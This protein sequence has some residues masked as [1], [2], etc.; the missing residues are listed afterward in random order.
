[1]E[2]VR[3]EGQ[4]GEEDDKEWKVNVGKMEERF[5]NVERQMRAVCGK[6][7]GKRW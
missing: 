5:S 2:I 7:I 3:D 6:G 1:M 4:V